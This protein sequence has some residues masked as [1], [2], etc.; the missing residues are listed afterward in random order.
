VDTDE[1]V[2]AV[3]RVIREKYVFPDRAL[4]MATVLLE[5][6][7]RYQGLAEPELCEALTADLH[8]VY[9]DLHLSVVYRPDSPAPEDGD[10]FVAW[11]RSRADGVSKVEHLK[12]NVG[13]FDLRNIMGPELVG[14][15]IAAAFTMLRHTEALILDLRGN[16]G[17]SPDGAAYFCS[18][19]LPPE[20]VHL[21]DVYSR[22]D[23]V[24][25]QYWSWP[26]VPGPRYLA[27]PLYVLTGPLTFSGGE[28][29]AYNLQQ[30]ARAGHLDATLIGETTRGGAH[31]TDEHVVNPVISVQVPEARSINPFTG[32]NWEGIGVV[33]DVT[34]AAD[35][36]FEA[37]Y[38]RALA[39]IRPSSSA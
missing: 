36:A 27:R 11:V 22:I 19:F 38:Q 28:E 13:L 1:T 34:I 33:P 12:G 39:Q 26:L 8:A 10:S 30:L 16:R 6:L 20:P 23:D 31:P 25:H 35:Q 24:T 14:E 21:N 2:R 32:T 4:A 17:G 29:I 7:P 15:T 9:A 5:G 37:A 3:A 18:Y